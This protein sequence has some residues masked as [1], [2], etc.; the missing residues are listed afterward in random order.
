MTKQNFCYLVHI[1]NYLRSTL[2]ILMLVTRL[3]LQYPKL[4]ILEFFDSSMTMKPRIS[5][6]IRSS[7]FQLRN[8]S[9]IRKYLIR[10][11]LNRSF[12]HSSLLVLTTKMLFFM[13]SQ[14][15]ANQLYRLQ[16]IQNYTGFLSIRGLFLNFWLLYINVP[17]ML[18]HLI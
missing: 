6:V 5:N 15:S 11:L 17:T 8:I 2:N 4:G 1:N 16:K 10:V 7:S 9:R 18:L 14:A 12:I 3:L 13:N